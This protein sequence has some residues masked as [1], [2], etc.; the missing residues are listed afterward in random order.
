VREASKWCLLRLSGILIA[1]RKRKKRNRPYRSVLFFFFFLMLSFWGL[2]AF[3]FDPINHTNF[4]KVRLTFVR[5]GG[6]T[7]AG[8][9]QWGKS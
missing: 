9:K 8:D 4:P 7:V 6:Q 2:T 5:C 3:L 1:N